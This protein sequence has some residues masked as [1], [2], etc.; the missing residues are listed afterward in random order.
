MMTVWC[1]SINVFYSAVERLI[2]MKPSLVNAQKKD[3]YTA[4][5][6]AAIN[7]RQD[8]ANILILKVGQLPLFITESLKF[9]CP[10][11]H[12]FVG[13]TLARCYQLHWPIISEWCPNVILLIV[14]TLAP[15]LGPIS[16]PCHICHLLILIQRRSK[17]RRIWALLD[18]R[19][20]KVRT[21]WL[22]FY[23]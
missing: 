8:S 9:Y 18:Q 16:T 15:H 5:H 20:A 14:P 21:I 1:F 22:T 2:E 17:V 6:I 13:P 12:D 23:S 19:W 4:L 3:G 10:R 7:D 11:Y